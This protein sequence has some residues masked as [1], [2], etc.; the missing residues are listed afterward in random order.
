MAHNQ[1][2]K[3]FYMFHRGRV[4][5]FNEPEAPLPFQQKPNP[6]TYPESNNPVYTATQCIFKINFNIVVPY[7]PTS[8]K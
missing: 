6:G 4:G 2:K 3:Q 1:D 5:G 7:T 8:A